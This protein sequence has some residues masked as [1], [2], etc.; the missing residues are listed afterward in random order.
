[1]SWSPRYLTVYIS[2]SFLFGRVAEA[3][4]PFSSKDLDDRTPFEKISES[5]ANVVGMLGIKLAENL[6]E[7]PAAQHIASET[8]MDALDHPDSLDRLEEQGNQS[9]SAY[10]TKLMARLA[11]ERLSDEFIKTPDGIVYASSELRQWITNGQPIVRGQVRGR[12]LRFEGGLV[13]TV[14]TAIPSTV[15]QSYIEGIRWV[16]ILEVKVEPS[17]V[18]YFPGPP[19]IVS[20]YSPSIEGQLAAI[21]GNT[22][23][24]KSLFQ[25]VGL[26]RRDTNAWKMAPYSFAIKCVKFSSTNGVSWVAGEL[27]MKKNNSGEWYPNEK[28][29]ALKNRRPRDRNLSPEISVERLNKVLGAIIID[30]SGWPKSHLDSAVLF[31]MVSCIGG[32]SKGVDFEADILSLIEKSVDYSSLS[33]IG[34]GGHNYNLKDLP[35]SFTRVL[36]SKCERS[37]EECNSRD[38]TIA[39]TQLCLECERYGLPPPLRL[40]QGTK[41][42]PFVG[43]ERNDEY[44]NRLVDVLVTESEWDTREANAVIDEDDKILGGRFIEYHKRHEGSSWLNLRRNDPT[45]LKDET[46]PL[47]IAMAHV[48]G[49][50]TNGVNPGGKAALAAKANVLRT[51]LKTE[52]Q[53]KLLGMILAL[54][55]Y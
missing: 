16:G 33:S 9:D 45:Y 15:D 32:L 4:S 31:P 22:R 21:S 53:R 28:I 27:P 43:V 37:E 41:L 25:T 29:S 12:A 54:E 24:I 36:S 13:S 11:L 8:W 34:R 20:N 40:I 3:S 14:A 26:G 51:K 35:L 46:D 7:N 2:L 42:Y 10:G 23:P 6:I 5:A 1:M 49:V 19:L 17:A 18:A 47:L 50:N 55:L 48:L 39:A 52:R 30:T 44:W 38:L